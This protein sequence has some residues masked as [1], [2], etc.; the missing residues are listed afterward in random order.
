MLPDVEQ[1]AALHTCK[2]NNSGGG[3]GDG[4]NFELIIYIIIVVIALATI[5]GG[6]W[7]D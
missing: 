6:S 1:I 4:P 7:Y 5:F 3:K 2:R